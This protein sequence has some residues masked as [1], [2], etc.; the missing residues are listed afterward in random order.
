MNELEICPK[1]QELLQWSSYFQK[2]E[3]RTCKCYFTLFEVLLSKVPFHKKLIIKIQMRIGNLFRNILNN[4]AMH[5]TTVDTIYSTLNNLSNFI[6]RP[7]REYPLK[8]FL[9]YFPLA[10]YEAVLCDSQGNLSWWKA[11]M[12]LAVLYLIFALCWLFY[13]LGREDMLI[14]IL[15]QLEQ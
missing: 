7:F 3:C 12:L 9:K 6:A 1:C 14:S 15:Q 8:D 11:R 4:R 5:L 10:L 13:D 2:Y